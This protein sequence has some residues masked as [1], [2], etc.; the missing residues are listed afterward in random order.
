MRSILD[1]DEVKGYFRL[2][3]DNIKDIHS[4]MYAKTFS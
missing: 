3:E 4:K 1:L 2:I